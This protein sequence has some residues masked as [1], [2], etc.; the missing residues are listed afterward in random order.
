[1]SDE[2]GK[3][4]GSLSSEAHPPEEDTGAGE[5]PEMF[6]L[7]SMGPEG[8]RRMIVAAPLP[9]GLGHS[10]H[11]G[12]DEPDDNAATRFTDTA[13][14][15]GAVAPQTRTMPPARA[16]VS[17]DKREKPRQAL[18]I[19]AVLTT[20]GG[21]RFVLRTIDVSS[22]GALL[23]APPG[24]EVAIREGTVCKVLLVH[25]TH[26]VDFEAGIVRVAEGHEAPAGYDRAFAVQVVLLTREQQQQLHRLIEA[27]TRSSR[28]ARASRSLRWLAVPL[29][30]LVVA[31]LVAGGLYVADTRRGVPV[32]VAVA[33]R[34]EVHEVASSLAYGEI[35]PEQ[36]VT[37]RSTLAGARVLTL[38][39][40]QGDRVKAGDVIARPT[41]HWLSESLTR[42]QTRLAQIE[43]TY[44]RARD[45]AAALRNKNV[46]EAE[47]KAA[48][49]NL[50]N[51]RG[52]LA[53]SRGEVEARNEELRKSEVQAPFGGVIA[54]LI[55]GSGE[56]VQPSAAICEL[57][58]DTNFHANVNFEE[59]EATRLK[60]GMAA[61]V[62]IPG[63]AEALDATVS[64]VGTVVKTD[65]KGRRVI[66]VEHGFPK[67]VHLRPGTTAK[68][69]ILLE[70]KENALL[71]PARAL[72][73][74]G[75]TRTA[76]IVG[77]DGRAT[78]AELTV[79]G[80]QGDQVEVL[81]GISEGGMIVLDSAAPGLAPNVRLSPKVE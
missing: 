14:A 65:K 41:E 34:G 15:V 32:A 44:R 20:P 38:A 3:I 68:A 43:N 71:V 1:V 64:K 6:R 70:T 40:K 42:S 60:P 49:D 45:Q 52:A 18:D 61:S 21:R 7:P 9:T 11:S 31:G 10:G 81:T 57:V 69:D 54:E 4:I 79:G 16:A 33:K 58:D 55:I 75:P 80:H 51:V 63:A 59:V 56:L 72:T 8:T 36:R 53:E 22:K 26:S 67:D 77:P 29:A 30:L 24:V 74:T 19:E 17:N 35:V 13:D 73:G 78:L 25:Q 76:Y 23:G 48:E 12:F 28:R 37:V 62:W 27:A 50:A 2:H 39:V 66:A 5:Q 46:P 47:L